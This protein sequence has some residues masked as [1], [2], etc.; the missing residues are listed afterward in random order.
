M[1]RYYRKSRLSIHRPVGRRRSGLMIV[2]A[3]VCLLVVTSI[4]GSMLRG[5]LHA[6]LELR[7]ERDRRQVELLLEAGADRA[8]ARFASEPEFRGD[9]WNLPAEAIVGHGDARVTTEISRHIDNDAWQ[10]H[11]IAEYPLGR[12][13]PTRRSHTF[14]KAS[15]IN[16]SQE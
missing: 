1:I 7:A 4:V 15:A 14:Q 5:A 10:V 16:Q 6:R 11:V 13:F 8:A 3:L 2:A 12:D 9:T